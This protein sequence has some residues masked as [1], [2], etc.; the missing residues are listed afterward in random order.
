MSSWINRNFDI[1][2]WIKLAS[3]DAYKFEIQRHQWLEDSISDAKTDLQPRLRG[4]LWELNMDLEISKHKMRKCHMI[5]RRV[6]AHLNDFKDV[7]TGNLP[8][9]NQYPA[10]IFEFVPREE[11]PAMPQ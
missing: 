1:D 7:L 6:V 9:T 3:D 5:S 11:Q 4:I 8:C 10:K 2:L